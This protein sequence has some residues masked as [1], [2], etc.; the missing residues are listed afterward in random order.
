MRL[1]KIIPLLICL[2]PVVMEAQALD[3]FSIHGYYKSYFNAYDWPNFNVIEEDSTY[4]NEVPLN[5]VVY[6]RVRLKASARISENMLLTGAYDLSPR[7]EGDAAPS[8]S[9]NWKNYISLLQLVY[10]AD[11]IRSRLY[12]GADDPEGNFSIYQNLD[13]LFLTLNSRFADFYIGRQAIAWG[14]AR[15]INPTD[16]LAPYAFNELD[17]EDRIGVDAA[18]IRIPLGPLS[19]IDAGAVFGKDFSYKNNAFFLRGKFDYLRNDVSLMTVA[20]RENLML[21]FD[22][23]RPIGGAGF[24]LEGGYVFDN[25]LSSDE[26]NSDNDFFRATIGCDYSLR[27]GTYLFMEYHYNGAGENDIESWL[28]VIG[29]SAY[30]EASGYL[31]GKHY[32]AP[33]IIHQ[34]TPLITLN[35]QMLAN[36]GDPS[37]FLMPTIE[38]NIAENIYLSG[39]AYLG[40]GGGA[41]IHT[42]FNGYSVRGWT[43]YDSEF[44]SYP[45][46]YFTSFR[47]Y[48]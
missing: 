30:I 43:D 10:R 33:G 20:F 3:W 19:E 31:I 36:L 48:F 13:R 40:L 1:N 5:A 12:P 35:G 32:L 24:W 16:V 21:G 27:D 45:D 8:P 37:F 14:S 28:E 42:W 26:R 29:N 15:V 44:G 2:L 23:T 39:G 38:Y 4:F 25:T 34:L 7:A 46:Y 18:R 11:D 6:N 41:T 22:W 47:I 17:V 9:S